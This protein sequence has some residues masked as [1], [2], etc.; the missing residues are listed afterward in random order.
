MV[1]LNKTRRHK[2]AG[3][4]ERLQSSP[5]STLVEVMELTGWVSSYFQ[6]RSN[7]VDNRVDSG[8]SKIREESSQKRALFLC[9]KKASIA[10]F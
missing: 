8:L 3:T 6:K 2:R 1:Q 4:I 9:I 7:M 5:N 10:D